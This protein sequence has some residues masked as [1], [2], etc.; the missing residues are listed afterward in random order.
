[1]QRGLRLISNDKLGKGK[2]NLFKRLIFLQP[3]IPSIPYPTAS[4]ST[5]ER[6]SMMEIEMLNSA[7]LLSLNS[8]SGNFQL[9]TFLSSTET[10]MV[11]KREED[12]DELRKWS[13][14]QCV[15]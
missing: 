2:G 7:R 15:T 4:T 6:V 9:K 12:K 5:K 13:S 14:S 3:A 10:V 1:M 11:D 8:C